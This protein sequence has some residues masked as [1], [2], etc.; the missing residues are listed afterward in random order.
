[1]SY[2]G[3]PPFG[4]TVRTVTTQSAN[5]SQTTFYP[6]G[7][8]IV[9]YLDV[10]YNGVK[11]VEATD[12]TASDGTS[13]IFTAAPLSN[14]TVEMISYG[15]ISL[16][17]SIAKS[18]DTMA[19][20]LHVRDVIPAANN[21]YNL[22]NNTN[23][24]ANVYLSGNTIILG[25]TVISSNS[26]TVSFTYPNNTP[27]AISAD[28]GTSIG[29]ANSTVEGLVLVAD[30]ISNSSV[31][32]AASA[33][34]VKTVS[35][36]AAN[37]ST[38]TSGTLNFARLPATIVQNTDSRTLSGNLIISGTYFNPA[39]NTVQLGSATERWVVSA[40]TIDASGLITGTAGANITGTSNLV[41]VF[42]SGNLTVS[43]TTTY[44]NTN[45]LNIGDNILT[46]NADLSGATAPTENAGIEVNRGSAANVSFVWNE[47]SDSWTSGNTQITGYAN[48]S[49]SV[50]SAILT[51]GSIVANATGVYPSSNT[52]GTALGSSTNRWNINANTGMF[53]GQIE[54]DHTWSSTTGA[55]SIYLD[56]GTGNRID[57][58]TSG[59][60]A[61]AVTTRSVG[62]KL[63]LYPSVTS[64][65]VDYAIGIES[66]HLW[67]SAGDTGSGIK[68]YANTTQ[69]MVVNTT[70]TTIS[71]GTVTAPNF[72]DSTG[73]YNVNLGSG[74]NEGRGLVAGYSGGAYGG[75]G[76]NIRHTSTGS[77]YIAP[78]GDTV[79][80]IGFDQGG[81]TFRTAAAG[82]AGRSITT[83]SGLSSIAQMFSN[84]NFSATSNITAYASDKRLKKNI[85]PISDAFY[86]LDKIEG[87]YFDW[88]LELCNKWNFNPPA[89]DAGLL[90]Q[91]VKEVYP[92]A[93]FDAPF[94]FDVSTSGS[95][96]GEH[97]L[98]VQYEKLVPVL[99]QA[100]KQLK[101]TC[102]QLEQR[103]AA[104]ES[105]INNIS[106]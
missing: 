2:L 76:Y 13:V 85:K 86:I 53:T 25:N 82:V 98:T 41:D 11:V 65:S 32:V 68:L 73:T 92:Y 87:V 97:Y 58:N 63:V 30:S 43:G 72:N 46:L 16:V 88:D 15:P 71:S 10:F 29:S 103:I 42:V 3:V 4:Q 93:V 45:N 105:T 8:Y 40:N 49:V 96:S 90:A 1:M 91:D 89:N 38:I 84:G 26:S 99:V 14:T 95:R 20:T 35:E 56:A 77:A 69:L 33:N 79:S 19:G 31:T 70:T 55:G 27:I 28:F 94:D 102:N 17:D 9:G 74:T 23:R 12:Y 80:Y 62:T 64:T 83:S 47:T 18:G 21:T 81:F 57:W 37:A 60:A 67:L 104:L 6:L 36:A 51:T 61:P 66:S 24:F 44:I 48:V 5:G 52:V 50:N 54:V 75:I 59:A 22:G 34:S 78:S 106:K 100:N 101:D 7:G 39:S